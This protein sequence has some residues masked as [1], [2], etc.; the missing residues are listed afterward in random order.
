MMKG[1]R[2]AMNGSLVRN[3]TRLARF[4][5]AF[6]TSFSVRSAVGEGDSGGEEHHGHWVTHLG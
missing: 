6:V 2:D 5:T 3:S 4:C 1:L